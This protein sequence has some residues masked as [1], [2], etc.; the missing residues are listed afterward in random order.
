M[1]IISNGIDKPFMSELLCSALSEDSFY[2]L[3]NSVFGCK[4]R[5][6]FNQ[7]RTLQILDHLSARSSPHRRSN[8]HLEKPRATARASHSGTSPSWTGA[9]SRHAP[10]RRA[11]PHVGSTRG[12]LS[13]RRAIDRTRSGCRHASRRCRR[14]SARRLGG[15]S[16]QG[17]QCGAHCRTRLQIEFLALC[18]QDPLSH[19]FYNNNISHIV[20]SA[21]K[22]YFWKKLLLEN[23]N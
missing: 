17:P 23:A 16:A 11:P 15:V 4:N 1:Y 8:E 14:G 9:E 18:V 5:L 7:E 10:T 22:S 21:K 12:V 6:R 20:W 13:R 3:Q 2:W 19:R